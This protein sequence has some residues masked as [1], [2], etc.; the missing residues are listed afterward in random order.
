MKE[1]KVVNTKG[2]CLNS[3]MAMNIFG[4]VRSLLAN[5][6]IWGLA[7]KLRTEKF[8]IYPTLE[9]LSTISV[10][11]GLTFFLIYNKGY[12][13]LTHEINEALGTPKA[14]MGHA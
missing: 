5:I 3:M 1:R 12:N 11:G 4:H 9:F 8:Y 6:H 10:E 2:M 13:I 14:T 7:D